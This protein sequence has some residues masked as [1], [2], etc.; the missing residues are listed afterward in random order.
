MSLSDGFEANHGENG[1][2]GVV[3]SADN[4]RYGVY[5]R[6][7]TNTN[8]ER[9]VL[10]DVVG[11]THEEQ[12]LDGAGLR[13]AYEYADAKYEWEELTELGESARES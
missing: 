2:L 6:E 8:E 1:L 11:A 3:S 13:G 7:P 9:V 12:A 10:L 4:T 5:Y